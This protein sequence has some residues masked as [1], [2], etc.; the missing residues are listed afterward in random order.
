M[1]TITIRIRKDAVY[2]EVAKITDYTGSKRISEREDARDKFLMTDNALADFDRLWD[3]SVL[4]INEKF[5]E[6]LVS[7]R[8][9]LTGLPSEPDSPVDP[10]SPSSVDSNVETLLFQSDVSANEA[11]DE[12]VTGVPTYILQLNVSDL[13]DLSLIE[14]IVIA[15]RSA[16][17]NYITG[18]WFVF[19]DK[20]ESMIYITKVSEMITLAEQLLFSRKRPKRPKYLE[21]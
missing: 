2:E 15:L 4:M 21:R 6:T 13:F 10:E 5:S 12:I 1:K 14:S 9:E 3:E 18:Q 19:M 16:M 20:D 11:A 8:T 17:V 7:G